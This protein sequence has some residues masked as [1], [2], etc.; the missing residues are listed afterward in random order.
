[1]ER[2]SDDD[3]DE[4][5]PEVLMVQ[6]PTRR[7]REQLRH[8]A[9]ILSGAE[10]V[11]A[12][13]GFYHATMEEI[14]QRAEFAI[15]SL[16]KYFR[17]KEAIYMALFE[18]RLH[19]F[20]DG[21]DTILQRDESFHTKLNQFLEYWTDFANQNQA[22]LR[23]FHC[24]QDTSD[25][26]KDDLRKSIEPHMMKYFQCMEQLIAQGIQEEVLRPHDPADLASFFIGTLQGF[27]FGTLRFAQ[28]VNV[29]TKLG[30]IRSLL[31]D[32]AARRADDIVSFQ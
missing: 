10:A 12:Q 17:S 18:E 20:T 28:D 31:L 13:K 27:F 4:D 11:F 8:R 24:S 30:V 3:T 19:R 7:D 22:L 32:G 2:C 29:K 25:W 1:M 23:I 26:H 21:I 16:Y 15:G 14:A 9:E 6:A 5:T